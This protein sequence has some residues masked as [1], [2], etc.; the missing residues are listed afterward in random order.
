MRRNKYLYLLN[1]AIPVIMLLSACNTPRSAKM[2]TLPFT[3]DALGEY[4]Y[5]GPD[6]LPGPKCTGDLSAWRAIVEA[7]GS[8]EPVGD[9]TIH[10]D[11]CGDA[12]G[13]YGNLYSYMLTGTGDTL[14]LEG[15]GKVMDGRL[16]EHPEFVTSYWKDTFRITGGSGKYKGAEGN[17]VSDDYNSSEDLFSHHHWSG[18]ITMTREEK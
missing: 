17:L 3:A 10:F 12:D 11:F 6:T 5:V 18:T 13:N 2:L 9:F 14:Y 7:K 8:G 15:S 16:D 1:L 4:L